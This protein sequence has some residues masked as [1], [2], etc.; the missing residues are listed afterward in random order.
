MAFPK[1][2]SF[3]DLTPKHF[4]LALFSGLLLTFSFPKFGHP[5]VAWVALLPLLSLVATNT[6]RACF[7][8][9]WFA[10]V[11]HGLSLLYWITFVV[12]HYGNLALPVSMGVCFLLV[13]YLAIFPGLFCAGLGWLRQ[14]G[15]PWLLFSPFL[16]VALELGKGRLLTGFPWE[17][18]G[19]S[20]YSWLSFIQI[21]DLAGVAGISFVLVLSNCLLFLLLL[22]HRGR[23]FTRLFSLALLVGLVLTIFGYGRWRLATLESNSGAAFKIALIQGNIAQETKWDPAFQQATLN[24]YLRLTRKVAKETPDLIVWPETAT[25]FFFQSDVKNSKALVQQVEELKKPLLFGSP[26]YRR[27]R[28]QLRLYNRAYLLNELG[29]ISSYY[30]KIHLVPFGEYV[31]FKQILFF[32]NKLVQAAGDF[33]SG[34]RAEVLESPPA[35]IGVLICYEGIFPEL[36]RDLVGAGANLLIN[37]TNDAWYGRSSAPHQ[38]LSMA[39]FRAVENRVPM[40]RCAN[41]GITAL[42]D[43]RGRIHQATGLFEEATIVGTVKLG[44]GDT[45]Y[46]RYGEWFAWG[47]LCVTLLVFGCGLRRG[48]QQADAET[49]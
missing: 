2:R 37:I 8:L 42:I 20:Q 21:A 23:A 25:P 30:D 6:P 19:H 10:G 41:T 17:N 7:S 47:C 16:W 39:V 48:H 27:E 31:P 22:D 15:L 1:I 36:S 33:V 43:A 35:R 4:F 9:G 12:N 38:H 24:K 44:L 29:R 14:R 5:L 45:V 18:L 3:F 11:C 28:D 26:A 40:A 46:Q 34:N 13:A 32:V 49:G